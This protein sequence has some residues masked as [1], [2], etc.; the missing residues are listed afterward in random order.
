MAKNKKTKYTPSSGKKKGRDILRQIKALEH[1]VKRW[2]KYR[3]SNKLLRRSKNHSC[4]VCKSRHNN[5]DIA[6][7]LKLISF[8][9]KV[10]S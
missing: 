5:W 8:L 3:N 2:D 9:K 1:K 10:K 4:N 7:F 6:G